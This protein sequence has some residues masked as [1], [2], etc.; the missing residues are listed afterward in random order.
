MRTASTNLNEYRE[1]RR[2]IS[3]SAVDGDYLPFREFR[4]EDYNP[5]RE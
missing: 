4:K 2:E 1:R 3:Y 5:F